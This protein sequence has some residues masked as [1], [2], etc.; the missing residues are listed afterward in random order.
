MMLTADDLWEEIDRLVWLREND[1]AVVYD[2]RLDRLDDSI[3]ADN[4]HPFIEDNIVTEDG[5]ETID[6]PGVRRDYERDRNDS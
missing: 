1:G 3:S 6:W 4:L 2:S 5:E